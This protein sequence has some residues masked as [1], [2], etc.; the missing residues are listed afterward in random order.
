LPIKIALK[1]EFIKKNQLLISKIKNI[2]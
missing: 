2:K 1:Y